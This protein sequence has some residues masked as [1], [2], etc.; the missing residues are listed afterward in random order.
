MTG[1]TAFKAHRGFCKSD[2]GRLNA[3]SV[4][5]FRY[6]LLRKKISRGPLGAWLIAW[7]L[8]VAPQAGGIMIMG[9]NAG[10]T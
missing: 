4:R 9:P 6:L 10:L 2:Q 5:R 7:S 8:L 1:A 3:F